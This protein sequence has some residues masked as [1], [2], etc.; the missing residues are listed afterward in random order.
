MKHQIFEEP[1]IQR[2]I[3]HD[4]RQCLNMKNNVEGISKGMN[5]FIVKSINT[6]N[7]LKEI[8]T[9]SRRS[10]PRS[11]HTQKINSQ[12]SRRASVSTVWLHWP[13]HRI[14]S[15]T[16]CDTSRLLLGNRYHFPAN[17]VSTKLPLQDLLNLPLA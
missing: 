3:P 10:R 7:K 12:C 1:F 5:K 17:I 16:K 15:I 2:A 8:E 11:N 14:I 6:S 9:V 13:G 4:L